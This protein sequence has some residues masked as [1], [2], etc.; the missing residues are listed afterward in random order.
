[1]RYRMREVDTGTLHDADSGKLL[2]ATV[3]RTTTPWERLRGLLARAPLVAGEGLLIDPCGSIH[4]FLMRYPIDVIYLSRD[5]VITKVVPSLV[6]FRFSLGFG[7]A[8]AL[9]LTAGAAANLELD[10]GRTLRWQARD[11]S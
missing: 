2:V 4:T 11:A 9:E 1:M 3:Y 6:P 5:L 7:A 10:R 8:M